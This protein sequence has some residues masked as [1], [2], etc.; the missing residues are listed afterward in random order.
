MYRITM[1]ASAVAGALLM[2][3]CASAPADAANAAAE[4]V[5]H[6]YRTG[7]L[8]AQKEKRPVT[9][10]ERRRAQEMAA[11]IRSAPQTITARP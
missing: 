4:P 3:G 11:E 8:I 5:A 7:S 6:E 9:D 1:T 2:A 10:E